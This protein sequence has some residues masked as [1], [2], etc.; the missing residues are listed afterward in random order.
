MIILNW[1]ATICFVIYLFITQIK[2]M[3]FVCGFSIAEESA[4]WGAI[5]LA[6]SSICFISSITSYEDLK[7]RIKKLEQK[8]GGSDA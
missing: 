4:L 5:F 6:I 3:C 1:L 7:E 8:G 2:P